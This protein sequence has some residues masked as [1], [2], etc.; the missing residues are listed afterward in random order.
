MRTKQNQQ[1]SQPTSTK[2]ANGPKYR[3]ATEFH[4]QTGR[5]VDAELPT[6][7]LRAFADG[8]DFLRAGLYDTKEPDIN[9][10][11]A[12]GEV[13]TNRLDADLVV[14]WY[15]NDPE[16]QRA[17]L[18]GV[19][20]K[21]LKEDTGHAINVNVPESLKPWAVRMPTVT[22]NVTHVMADSENVAIA[23]A[24]ITS[25][26]HAPEGATATPLSVYPIA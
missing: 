11:W 7:A 25:H 4:R 23:V 1:T 10:H 14:K 20:Y 19:A 21:R 16:K 22:S 15:P 18:L 5:P 26:D 3:L 9:D 12:H 2:A 24:A 8:Y 17:T 6:Q 13:L